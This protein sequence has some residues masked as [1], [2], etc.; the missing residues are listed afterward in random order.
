MALFRWL[1]ISVMLA[2]VMASGRLH[3]QARLDWNPEH[4]SV[5]VVGV[6]QWEHPEIWSPFPECQQD[7]RDLQL[8]EQFREAGVP[9]DR[10]AYLC[11]GQATKSRIQ[12]AFYKLLDETGRGDLLVFY[13]CGHGYRDSDSG[14]TWFANYDAGKRDASAWNVA[15]IFNTIEQHFRGD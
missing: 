1:I 6:L 7:R 5:F 4:T 11:D 8:V 3:A 12:E 10:I 15:G 2:A 13:F 14:Q 9:E